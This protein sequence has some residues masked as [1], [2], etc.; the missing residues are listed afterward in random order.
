MNAHFFVYK[1]ELE[2]KPVTNQRNTGRCWIF[3]CLN[4]LRL[5]VIKHFNLEDFEFSQAYLFFWDKVE[6][7]NFFLKNVIEIT[8]RKEPIDGRLMAY[9]LNVCYKM[10]SFIFCLQVNY[11]GTNL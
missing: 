3:A 6:R 5:P 9:I 2:G 10:L 8:R 4:V 1:V 7:C 11:A